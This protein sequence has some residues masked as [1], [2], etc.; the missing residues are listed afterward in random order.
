MSD[1]PTPT[2]QL[3]NIA[4]ELKKL[5]EAMIQQ[6]PMTF[7]GWWK[8]TD[9]PGDEKTTA[10]EGWFARNAEIEALKAEVETLKGQVVPITHW[11]LN[12]KERDQLR[13][14]VEELEAEVER[15][16]KKETIFYDDSVKNKIVAEKMGD[17]LQC[18]DH[19][20][21]DNLFLSMKVDEALAAYKYLTNKPTS[22][23]Q[24][25]TK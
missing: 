3:S 7:E 17:A 22:D 9:I 6:P 10:I 21:G 16:K 8:T 11:E 2:E 14:R 23:L 4:G 19:W 12:I 5:D 1:T 13:N 15:L 18:V 20:V 25:E 24:K